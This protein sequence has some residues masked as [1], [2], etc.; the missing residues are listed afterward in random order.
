MRSDHERVLGID[1]G[2]L[3]L[4]YGVIDVEGRSSRLVNHGCIS[5]DPKKTL[6][7]RLKRLHDGIL[8]VIGQ[9]NPDCIAYEALVYHK[10]A[11]TALLLGQ[12]RGAVIV[13]AAGRHLP[14][15]EFSPT[16]VK[17]AIQGKGRASKEQIQKMVQM[18]LG[19]P[20]VPEPEHA[21]D[22]LAVAL[23]YAHERSVKRLLD[24]A[25]ASGM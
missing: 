9:H 16:A 19:L 3:H 18:L 15:H 10:N 1:P 8:D 24:Q 23:T 14:M 4:G 22:A 2:L 12:A 17:K 21:A 7:D 13:A 5:P 11:R 20:E 25:T 6:P